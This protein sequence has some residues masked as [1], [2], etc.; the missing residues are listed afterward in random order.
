MSI[1]NLN[2]SETMELGA[3]V[4]ARSWE[5]LF[6][7]QLR[8]GVDLHLVDRY[9]ATVLSSVLGGPNAVQIGRLL[10]SENSV[11]A[12]VLTAAR[13]VVPQSIT[14]DD[15]YLTCLP[16]ADPR[17]DVGVLVVARRA[18]ASG[19]PDPR[20]KSELERVGEWLCTAVQAHLGSALPDD[21]NDRITALLE[22]LR[23]AAASGSDRH[24]IL[25]WAE[26]MA[27]WHDLDVHAYVDDLRGHFVHDAALP[28][29]NTEDVPAMIDAAQLEYGTH[30]VPMAA[31]DAE[32]VGFATSKDV[33]IWKLGGNAG[34]VLA[35]RGSMA[36]Q[37]GRTLR[38][39]IRLLEDTVSLATLTVQTHCVE[40]M[41]AYLFHDDNDIHHHAGQA[42]KTL[43]DALGLSVASLTV[44]SSS[45]APLLVVGEWQRSA[46]NVRDAGSRL[47]V[48]R[49]KEDQYSLALG[50]VKAHERHI[51]PQD[52][53]VIN[54][55]VD[56]LELWAQRLLGR[57][58]GTLERR[59]VPRR[60][61]MFVEELAVQASERKVPVAGMV[62]E[63]RPQS[64]ASTVAHECVATLRNRM[65]ACD[66]V[67]MLSETDIGLLLHN[68]SD[69]DA[70]VVEAR[71]RQIMQ[72][73]DALL[74]AEGIAIGVATRMPGDAVTQP[75]LAE[76]RARVPRSLA[77]GATP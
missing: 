12:A 60:F 63:L 24:V 42:V 70:P 62:I 44:R 35:V 33:V 30:L 5:W 10:S 21:A 49:H 23:A 43:Q 16:V 28:G 61:D 34:W 68:T 75:I 45:G 19:P 8:L 59:A 27:I 36:M 2:A 7:L 3:A 51:T 39:Y 65:R 55:A 17:T 14:A 15:A 67:G 58:T 50:V 32:R 18:P 74:G 64:F 13:T 56:L 38:G 77:R 48:L 72:D 11:R 53:R 40:S 29:A 37:E 66:L 22:V 76:A 9:G 20:V 25:T 71:V 46:A 1:F 26:A 31:Q 52:A 54:K 6:T 41:T 4:R 47:V 73:V 57:A 69:Q